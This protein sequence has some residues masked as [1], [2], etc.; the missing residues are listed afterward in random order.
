[1][2]ILDGLLQGKYNGVDFL[3][4]ESSRQDGKKLAVHEYPQRNTRTVTELGNLMPIYSLEVWTTG[5]EQT[6]FERR[7]NLIK[8]FKKEGLATFVHPIDGT[9]KATAKDFTVNEEMSSSGVAKFSV[10][11]IPNTEPDYPKSVSSGKSNTQQVFND[12]TEKINKSFSRKWNST[13]KFQNSINKYTNYINQYTNSLR[14]ALSLISVTASALAPFFNALENLENEIVENILNPSK[15]ANSILS[16]YSNVLNLSA[17][18]VGKSTLNKNFFNYSTSGETAV[19]TPSR[20]AAESNRKSIDT[21]I[22]SL[23]LVNEF[24]NTTNTNYTNEDDIRKQS[25]SLNEQYN[26]LVINNF[27]LDQSGNRNQLFDQDTVD[28]ITFMRDQVSAY[29]EAQLTNAKRIETIRVSRNS[30]LPLVYQYYGSLDLYDTISELNKVGNPSD[31]T[32]NIK[33]LVS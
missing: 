26:N 6:Y 17:V 21:Y 10:T 29:L 19:N 30:L 1:M 27:S 18:T 3:F 33:I 9:M 16:N 31:I 23:S 13:I 25:D 22:N 15:L 28:S 7:L 8:A 5:D 2:S 20:V 12:T 14:E 11:I 24:L 32:G 4:V